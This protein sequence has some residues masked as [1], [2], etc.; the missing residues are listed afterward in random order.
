MQ[1]KI[2][3]PKNIKQF[4]EKATQWASTFP[5]ATILSSQ[6]ID[7]YPQGGFRELIAVGAKRLLV[8]SGEKDLEKLETFAEKGKWTFGIL[9]YELKNQ[10]E[11]L[12]SHSPNADDL[13][14]LLFFEP[15]YVLEF[16][17]EKK[18][19]TLWHEAGE[20]SEV[21]FNE[22]NSVALK[23]REGLPALSFRENTSREDYIANVEAIRELIA[24]GDMYEVNYCI[25]FETE[26]KD[27]TLSSAYEALMAASPMPFSAYFRAGER[28]LACASPERF[29]QKKGNTLWTQPIKGTIR[30]GKDEAED[31]KLQQA[32]YNSEK[33]RAENL[34]IV[35]LV[36]NDLSRVGK[37]GTTQVEEL[38]GI[39]TFKQLHQMISTVKSE[40][41]EGVGLAEI[42]RATF[43]MGSM[44]GAPKVRAMERITEFET[45]KRGWYSGSVGYI[46][47]N[48]D[49]DFNVIIRSLVLNKGKLNYHVGSAITYDAEA[50]AE[51]EECLLKAQA[52]RRIFKAR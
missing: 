45:G 31:K 36:R 11:E 51:Y 12:P 28:A 47:P 37:V 46:S 43:P 13:P 15:E 20:E 25:S 17:T 19:V 14:S 10:I 2:Y 22:I 4:K 8:A 44:T 9:G 1:A 42:L 26:F 38:F 24:A 21:L 5:Y 52:M 49:F 18:E 41:R 39:Y 33:E 30:R 40:Q 6:G 35:D 34:M 16:H 23:K 7:N 3:T 48:G 29:L 27:D 32:L 50:K